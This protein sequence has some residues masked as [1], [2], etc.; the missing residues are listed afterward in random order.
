MIKQ[1]VTDICS[2]NRTNYDRNSAEIYLS[3]AM[4]HAEACGVE[5]EWIRMCL[6]KFNVKIEAIN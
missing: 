2:Q 1:A 3:R 6:D 4:Y 5:S